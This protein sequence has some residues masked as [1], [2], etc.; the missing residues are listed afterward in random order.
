MLNTYSTGVRPREIV[1]EPSATPLGLTLRD[2]GLL[3]GAHERA[4]AALIVG[5]RSAVRP[6]PWAAAVSP[7]CYSEAMVGREWPQR[8][9]R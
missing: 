6:D 4:N 5:S 8:R 7:E 3:L 1:S 9:E 2:V